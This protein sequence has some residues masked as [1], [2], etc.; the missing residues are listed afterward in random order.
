M[1]RAR[2]DEAPAQDREQDHDHE[3]QEEPAT[4][5]ASM[6]P[7]EFPRREGAPILASN[8]GHAM[9]ASPG[10]PPV[11]ITLWRSRLL[12]I[13]VGFVACCSALYSFLGAS[14]ETRHVS[15]YCSGMVMASIVGCLLV[16]FSYCLVFVVHWRLGAWRRHRGLPPLSRVDPSVLRF[17]GLAAVVPLDFFLVS[18]WITTVNGRALSAARAHA[19]VLVEEMES[20]R[21]ATGS[22]PVHLEQLPSGD[23]LPLFTGR[24]EYEGTGPASPVVLEDTDFLT[25]GVAWTYD[26]STRSW[27]SVRRP[28]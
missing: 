27:K 8:A 1:L 19:E 5:H 28:S 9:N 20:F 25:R 22:Y 26:A 6:V 18:C 13:H 4:V 3:R 14:P 24:F 12:W 7:V 23:A 21:T 17:V 16:L 10:E 2:F 11:R 15:L